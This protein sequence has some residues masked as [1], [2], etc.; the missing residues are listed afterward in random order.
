MNH[1]AACHP[2]WHKPYPALLQLQWQ[3]LEGISFCFVVLSTSSSCQFWQTNRNPGW[4]AH[5]ILKYWFNWDVPLG[6]SRTYIAVKWSWRCTEVGTRNLCL[7]GE[8]FFSS[9]ACHASG[10]YKLVFLVCIFSKNIMYCSFWL[11]GYSCTTADRCI[12]FPTSFFL[13]CLG[14]VQSTGP[15]LLSSLANWV[16]LTISETTLVDNESVAVHDKH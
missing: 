2:L 14:H 7:L 8:V 6:C 4:E 10:L 13:S 9:F 3:K 16:N 5:R 11:D 1:I 15:V 12:E